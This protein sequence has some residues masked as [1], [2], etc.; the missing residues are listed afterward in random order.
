MENMPMPG[1]IY[2]KASELDSTDVT[3]LSA[4]GYTLSQLKENDE[5]IIYI[6][7]AL[8]ISPNNINLLGTLG[9]IYDTQKK[10]NECDSVYLKALSM[11]ST[12]ALINNNYAYSLSERGIKLDDALRMSKLS[13]KAEPKNSA[14]L[15]TMGWNP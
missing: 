10:W 4:F 2:K 9:L 13:V 15:D 12:N 11:D 7:K 8:A 5:A 6:K 1:D 14:Y 3:A